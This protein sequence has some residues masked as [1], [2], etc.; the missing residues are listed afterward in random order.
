MAKKLDAM[1]NEIRKGVLP[2]KMSSAD[3]Q[4]MAA[5]IAQ[6]YAKR[7]LEGR[8]DELAK[9]SFFKKINELSEKERHFLEMVVYALNSLLKKRVLNVTNPLGFFL[10]GL[11]TDLAPEL[12]KRFINGGEQKSIDNFMALFDKGLTKPE[13]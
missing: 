5:S 12:M 6:D 11:I 3:L 4:F 10:S 2:A 1:L 13:K 7:L 8:Y 9:A